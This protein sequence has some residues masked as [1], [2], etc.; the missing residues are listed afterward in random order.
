MYG[1]QDGGGVGEKKVVGGGGGGGGGD[2]GVRSS[3]WGR[4]SGGEGSNNIR[5]AVR[6]VFELF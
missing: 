4:M 1:E 3:K 6:I 2:K 5:Q